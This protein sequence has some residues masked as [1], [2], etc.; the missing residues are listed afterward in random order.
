MDGRTSGFEPAGVQRFK[1][2]YLI[3]L[4]YLVG[5]EVGAEGLEPP[6]C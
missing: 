6:T 2:P 4:L 5:A 1:V 3:T